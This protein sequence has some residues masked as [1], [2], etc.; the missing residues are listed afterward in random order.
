M[1]KR[2]FLLLPLITAILHQTLFAQKH[3]KEEWLSLF[4]G[5]DLSG[6]T[7]KIRNHP[8]G[9]NFGNT[10]RVV[11]GS[12]A[13]RYEAYDR[14]DERFGHLFYKNPYGYYRLQMEYR[15]VDDQAKEGPGWA[16]RNSGVMV[17]GQP[18]ETMGRDQDFPVSIE[19]QFLG[20][21]GKDPRTTCN[22]C[23]PGTHVEMEGKLVTAHCINS[24]SETY[25][26]DQW[27]KV[28]IHVLGDS[29]IRHFANGKEVMSYKRPQIGGGMVNKQDVIFGRE[30][31]PLRRGTISLQS[32]SHPV[33]FRNIR[34]LDLEGCMD[35][36]A[37]NY[38]SYHVRSKPEDCRYR[39]NR[40]GKP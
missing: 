10:F 32:E 22:L 2:L 36:K 5:K 37:T 33:E 13:V 30:G 4:N 1:I 26:G 8:S 6:W 38:K 25:H 28:E 31:Q 12:I 21:N 24:Q 39:N 17:H 7:P 18:P 9:E 14:F 20:G 40:K 34:L 3:S 19:I 15:F 23:T 29:L 27:V 11:D 16:F 35:P